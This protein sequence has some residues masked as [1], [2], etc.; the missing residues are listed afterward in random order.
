MDCFSV[1]KKKDFVLQNPSLN[2]YLQK[3][4]SMPEIKRY[5]SDKNLNRFGTDFKN[6]IKLINDSHGEFDLAIRDDYL[7]IYYKGNSLAKI[8]FLEPDRYKV[9]IHKKFFKGT[10]AD[11]QEFYE[12]VSESHNYVSLILNNKKTP[13]RFFQKK[14]INQ[15]CSKIKKVNYGEEIVFEQA[16]I[17]DNLERDDLII[18]DRQITDTKLK[19]KRM[20][21][22]ALKR[23]KANRYCFLVIEVKLGNNPELKSDVSTQLNGY[24]NHIEKHFT[25]YQV[26]YEKQ[27]E[28]KKE[29]GLINT[30]SFDKIKIEKPVRGMVVVGGY[31]KIARN[32]IDALKQQYPSLMVK[33]FT[34]KI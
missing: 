8:S 1:S 26:C 22:L 20:D 17:T 25:D 19:R 30:P 6:L 12:K 33:Q 16:L 10:S 11:S 15:F 21:L 32:N 24:L 3:E 9:E 7:N 34:Y 2:F 4:I 14:H 13:R 5:L 28:Q 29:I 18:I 31:S 23:V 27:F